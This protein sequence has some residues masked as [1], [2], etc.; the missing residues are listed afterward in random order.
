MWQREDH[1]EVGDGKQLALPFF[2]PGSASHCLALGTVSVAAG[3]V[4]NPL[5]PAVVALLQMATQRC[6]PA[7]H[8]RPQHLP[9]F[10]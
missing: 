8:Y 2:Q 9:L 5:V 7:I 4:L 6:S 1:V 10:P 3:I